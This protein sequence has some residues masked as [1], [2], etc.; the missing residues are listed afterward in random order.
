[1]MLRLQQTISTCGGLVLLGLMVFA[2]S[3]SHVEA[4]EIHHATAHPAHEADQH[5]ADLQ[6]EGD[7]RSL[8]RRF[9]ETG[10]DAHLEQAWSSIEASLE[11]DA[12][13]ADLL[14]DAALV[15]QARHQFGF[16]LETARR[17]VELQPDYDQAWLL[18][19]A[20][21]LVLGEADAAQAAC[22][23]LQ[24]TSWL[25]IVGCHTRV[26][27]ARGESA[28]IRNRIT[29][30]LEAVDRTRAD[31]GTVAWLLSIA[32]DISVAV[33]DPDQAIGYFEQSLAIAE[34]TQVRAALV[35]T[36]IEAGRL[37][38][39]AGALAEGSAALPLAVRRMIVARRSGQGVA[40]TANVAA[41][42]SAFQ[43][44]IAAE[45]WLHAR[46]MA[47]FYLDVL[48]RPELARR[49]ALIN[50]GVQ[51]EPE[52]LRLVRRT[53]RDVAANTR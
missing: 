8:L 6:R 7:I 17:A 35:D 43:E 51:R 36:L 37:D 18:I 26:A 25:L 15:A 19:A 3:A 32:G 28:E 46:E 45:D 44:W 16:A 20:V 50:V 52:D 5:G 21:H 1:M 49:L 27:H 22:N 40:V 39:A 12:P 9:R 47:R 29:Q 30:L 10:D 14:V 13:D 4:H 34:N 42:D 48:P 41:A 11:S 24:R 2:C 23:R 53:S 33:G 31:G 38:A